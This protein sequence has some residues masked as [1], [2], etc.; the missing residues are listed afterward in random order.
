MSAERVRSYLME[1]GVRYETHSHPTAYTTSEIAEAEHVPGER[2]AKVVMVMAGERPIMAVLPGDKMVDL[3]KMAAAIDVED[4]RLAEES[5]F[6]PLFPDCE[7]GAEPPFGALY[8]VSTVV[9][10]SL[11]S[12]E[13]TFN[14]GTHEESITLGLEDYLEL[15]N[16]MR[17]DLVIGA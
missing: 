8:D 13:I 10:L 12:P 3:E 5:E 9:D 6:S 15:T 1:H 7:I 11:D 16:P 17:A 2:V 14:A 4:V